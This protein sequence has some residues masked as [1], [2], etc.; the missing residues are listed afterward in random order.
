MNTCKHDG[1]VERTMDQHEDEILVVDR[2]VKCN[3]GQTRL[4]K[5]KEEKEY[6]SLSDE[7]IEKARK[8]Y[9]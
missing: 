5:M 4:Y 1:E 6:E 8:D 3:Y 7:Q 2:C 9:V